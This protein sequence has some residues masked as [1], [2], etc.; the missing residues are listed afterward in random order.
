MRNKSKVVVTLKQWV[1]ESKSKWYKEQY[2]IIADRIHKHLADYLNPAK[3]L[4][5]QEIIKKQVDTL[6]K[7]PVVKTYEIHK[8]KDNSSI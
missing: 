5:I 1:L 2:R 3:G 6:P 4:K 7:Y 8:N